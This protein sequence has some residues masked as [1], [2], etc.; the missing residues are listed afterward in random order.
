MENLNPIINAEGNLA[1]VA[2]GLRGFSVFAHI[3][4]D[5][6]NISEA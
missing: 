3:R 6:P 1:G 5:H 2:V 4:E